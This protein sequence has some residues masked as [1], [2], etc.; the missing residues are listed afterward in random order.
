MGSEKHLLYFIVL[1][2]AVVFINI[3]VYAYRNRRVPGAPALIVLLLAAMGYAVP[4]TLQMTSPNL[5]IARLWYLFSIPGANLLAPAWLIF[6]LTWSGGENTYSRRQVITF[7][8]GLLFIPMLVCLAA[9]TNT[10]H[11]LYG[12]NFLFD[13]QKSIPVLVWDFGIFYW[14][15]FLYAYGVLSVGL[16]ILLNK[17]FKRLRLFFQQ[18]ML[19]L[20]G[21]L[22]PVFINIA[23]AAGFS[24]IPGFDLAP[25]TFLVT[26]II[27]SIAVFRFHFLEIEPIDHQIDFNQIPTGKLV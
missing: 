26:G 8:T 22:I 23:F 12:N 4:Y 9:W 11:S 10:L 3:A 16:I 13:P 17:V 21:A 14:V 7:L 25:Y 1:V 19:M 27:W 24:F 15:G 5:A 20:V 6:S 2:I 18:S